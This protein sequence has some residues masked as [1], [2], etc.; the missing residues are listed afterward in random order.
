[1]DITAEINFVKMSHNEM[2]VAFYKKSFPEMDNTLFEWVADKKNE[3]MGLKLGES[4]IG[5]ITFKQMKI[6]NVEFI[7]LYLLCIDENFRSK[8]YG[9]K[10]V[11][12]LKINNSKILAW[13]DNSAIDF[14]SKHNFVANQELGNDMQYYGIRY[15]NKS[16]FH[17]YGLSN[18]DILELSC[19][20]KLKLFKKFR[21]KIA[22]IITRRH[23]YAIVISKEIEFKVFIDYVYNLK[24][25]NKN[26]VDV[27]FNIEDENFNIIKFESKK[28][29]KMSSKKFKIDTFEKKYVDICIIQTNCDNLFRSNFQPIISKISNST[30]LLF[31]EKLIEGD[32]S[33]NTI[34]TLE[35]L[36]EEMC[37]SFKINFI[38]E[39]SCSF[40]VV[41]I[42]VGLSIHSKRGRSQIYSINKMMHFENKRR[43]CDAVYSHGDRLV[44]F[45]FK[46]N[47]THIQNSFQY[48]NDRDYPV[49]L[50]NYLKST[51]PHQIEGKT[52]LGRIGIEFYGVNENYK[53]K[54]CVGEDLNI[55]E[56]N[57]NTQSANNKIIKR[58]INQTRKTNIRIKKLQ[59]LNHKS[60]I[61]LNHEMFENV[62]LIWNKR[63]RIN[64]VKTRHNTKISNKL[65]M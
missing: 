53:V 21:L 52:K 28:Q 65:T 8:N 11:E 5:A 62:K 39:S 30:I 14:F 29:I 57:T 25:A 55:D 47:T 63:K 2:I 41:I 3:T 51:E 42:L 54:F 18:D 60:T 40:I 35:K 50:V 17:H 32:Y 27:E 64:N 4:L 26:I 36:I 13:V 49:C 34:A 6:N 20:K 15:N 59:K 1:M 48:I 38:N 58:K 7:Y 24:S 44:I 10:L 23:M 22:D 12:Y 61:K 33:V 9:S 19:Q 46:N 43:A 37:S 31:T 56:I 45:E 16:T